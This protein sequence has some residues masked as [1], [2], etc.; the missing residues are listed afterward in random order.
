M[1]SWISLRYGQYTETQ[2]PG[3]TCYFVFPHAIILSCFF[4]FLF[5]TMPKLTLQGQVLSHCSHLFS[6]I[7]FPLFFANFV[8][9]FEMRRTWNQTLGG[10]VINLEPDDIS[11]VS[12]F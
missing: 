11:L 1:F 6:E 4:V 10:K 7:N 5:F 3:K 9:L 8:E 12:H 2:R